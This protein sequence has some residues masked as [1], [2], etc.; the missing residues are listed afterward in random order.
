MPSLHGV[1]GRSDPKKSLA[2]RCTRSRAIRPSKERHAGGGRTH[3]QYRRGW[4][5]PAGV[6]LG[7]R[8][9]LAV[10][11]RLET[12][13]SEV[14]AVGSALARRDY[15]ALDN[16][17]GLVALLSKAP[18]VRAVAR[19]LARRKCLRATPARRERQATPRR[20]L[21][22]ARNGSFAT[23]QARETRVACLRSPDRLILPPLPATS[24]CRAAAP[25]PSMTIPFLTSTS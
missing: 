8:G 20:C 12:S 14:W 23:I 17:G 5:R 24:A 13:P 11:D 15:R 22:Q 21:R 25:V 3:H 19:L 6:S 7:V 1:Q 18:P 10:N 4:A 16:G 9:Y 2:S